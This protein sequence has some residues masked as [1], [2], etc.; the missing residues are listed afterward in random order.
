MVEGAG[1][2]PVHMQQA[3][4]VMMPHAM[5]AVLDTISSS[6]PVACTTLFICFGSEWRTCSDSND[7]DGRG[8]TAASC[9]H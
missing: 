9:A 3:R 2:P 5:T 4:P 6:V 1:L 7:Y 8:W